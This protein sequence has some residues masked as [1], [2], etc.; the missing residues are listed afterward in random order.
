L[1]P[2]ARCVSQSSMPSRGQHFS[3]RTVLLSSLV[4]IAISLPAHST[5]FPGPYVSFGTYSGAQDGSGIVAANF[6]SGPV[7]SGNYSF[8]QVQRSVRG[9]HYDDR[10]PA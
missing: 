8:S 5:T 9:Q 10:Q 7:S 4:A 1:R 3:R 2:D 6:V